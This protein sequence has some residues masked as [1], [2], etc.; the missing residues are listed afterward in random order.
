MKKTLLTLVLALVS[1][2]VF[3]QGKPHAKIFSNF[4]YDLS[5]EEDAQAFK[6]FEIKRVYLG[7]SHQMSDEFSAKVT[8]DVGSNDGG[9]AY[10]MLVEF[11]LT[12]SVSVS[13]VK[14]PMVSP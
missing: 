9:S 6:E 12:K 3:A 14:L 2:G 13:K 7:Y 8:F 1:L 4:N 5:A 10:K 11:G